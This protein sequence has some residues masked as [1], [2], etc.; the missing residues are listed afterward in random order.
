[1]RFGRAVLETFTHTSL[2]L[3]Q[4]FF[5]HSA[6]QYRTSL[7]R[8]HFFMRPAPPPPPPPSPPPSS[9]SPATSFSGL[10]QLAHCTVASLR[11]WK[12]A[13]VPSTKPVKVLANAAFA[14]ALQSSSA[15][16]MHTNLLLHRSL[17]NGSLGSEGL[18]FAP[19][20][21]KCRRTFKG[22]GRLNLVEN[23]CAV[24]ASPPRTLPMSTSVPPAA[25]I[26]SHCTFVARIRSFTALAALSRDGLRRAER[27]GSPA[28]EAQD[29][30]S[31]C[32]ASHVASISEEQSWRT[33]LARRSTTPSAARRLIKEGDGRHKS[34]QRSFT[35][36]CFKGG[37]ASAVPSAEGP[38]TNE[39]NP[40]KEVAFC[41]AVAALPHRSE[42]GSRI[43]TRLSAIMP[44]R[45]VKALSKAGPARSHK[46]SASCMPS[47]SPS[48][49]AQASICRLPPT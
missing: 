39:M 46:S 28:A 29:R 41:S 40:Q 12:A 36:C 47:K 45:V 48:P 5:W 38:S 7:H 8:L 21:A 44:S 9:P 31:N 3:G 13:H 23:C 30:T 6:L 22:T 10:W 42:T 14:G 1:M 32:S 49:M 33:A 43:K 11:A 18:Y 16:R 27:S 34:L 15:T 20:G 24:V 17:S 25:G 26:V 4:W 35:A 19:K 37:A 2:C